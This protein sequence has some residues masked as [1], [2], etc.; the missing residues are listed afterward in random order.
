MRYVIDACNLIFSNRKLEETLDQRGFQA[1]RD[2][3][4]GMLSR[5]A[6]VNG[7]EQ[8]TAVFD[9]SEKGAHRPRMSREASGKVVLIYAD[10]RASAD[11]FI[12]EMVEDALKPG[13]IVV[14][15]NDKFVTRSVQQARGKQMSCGA[16]MKQFQRAVKHAADPLK[17]ENPRKYSDVPLTPREIEEWSEYFGFTEDD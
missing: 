5:F 2:L 7:L 14:V 3:L 17:G 8:V 6:D 11:R 10:P 16:F 15:S 12:I 9:G 1:A 13:E 4:V